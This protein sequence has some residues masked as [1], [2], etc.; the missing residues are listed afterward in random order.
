MHRRYPREQV[1]IL[2]PGGVPFVLLG[3]TG[4]NP[5]LRR[6][7]CLLTLDDVEQIQK[8][9]GRVGVVPRERLKR[10]LPVQ[11]DDGV[12][13]GPEKVLGRRGASSSGREVVEEANAGGSISQGQ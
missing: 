8:G 12:T 3:G 1:A 5:R 4:R 10:V 7:G 6:P 9:V 13:A 11:E 2:V